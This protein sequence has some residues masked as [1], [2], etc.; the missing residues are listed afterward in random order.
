MNFQPPVPPDKVA[1]MSSILPTRVWMTPFIPNLSTLVLHLGLPGD[2]VEASL[3]KG[4]LDSGCCRG[5]IGASWRV[6]LGTK[7][8]L[9]CCRWPG[10][11]CLLLPRLAKLPGCPRLVRAMPKWRHWRLWCDQLP[12]VG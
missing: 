2:D 9:R 5:G 6:T 1:A 4:P 7:R 11:G 12:I 10:L 3:H 8:C